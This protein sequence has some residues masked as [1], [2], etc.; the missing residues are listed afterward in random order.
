MVCCCWWETGLLS[1][2]VS[3]ARSRCQNRYNSSYRA[4]LMKWKLKIGLIYLFLVK[5]SHP[6]LKRAEL[7]QKILQPI[8]TLQ[9]RLVWCF[10]VSFCGSSLKGE[11]GVSAVLGRRKSTWCLFLL[12]SH[13]LPGLGGGGMGASQGVSLLQYIARSVGLVP[14]LVCLL[15]PV[16]FLLCEA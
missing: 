12:C 15:C 5:T 16:Q 14:V 8:L 10:S 7:L 11:L 2:L 6:F 3:S 13:M 9:L 1:P 4:D